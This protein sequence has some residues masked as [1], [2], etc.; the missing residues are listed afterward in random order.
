LA[1]R[2]AQWATGAVG[3]A[4]LQELIE[5]PDYQLVGVLVYDPAK[6]GQDA[7]ALCGLPPT[8]GVL[9]T[10]DK[11]EILAIKP[12]V[13]VHA[14]SKAHTVETN[15]EDIC[16]L[17]AAGISVITTT[18]YNHLPTYGADVEATFIEACQQGQSRFHAAGENPGF[19]FERLVAT[20]TALCKTIDRI[21]LYEA[22]DV[23]AVDSRPMLV[24]LMGMGR[25][26]EDVSIDSPIVKKLDMA[27]RQALN[28]TADVLGVTLSHVD[29]SVDAT[30]LSHDLE[31]LAGTI[32]AGTVVGQRFS[33]VG[34]WSGRTLLA[35]HEEWV[36]TRDLPQWGLKPLAPGEKAPL[37]RAVI[38]G[39]PS[40]DFQLDVGWD[41]ALPTGQHAQPGHLMIAMGAVRAIR[42]VLAHPPG[43]VTAP[44]FGAIQLG[45]GSESRADGA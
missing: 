33:W 1:I 39:T 40:F 27:Y 37:I 23:S 31:V 44:V 17:L 25:P 21:D 15:A 6:A 26:P 19:M 36:L 18:S 41:G 4:A 5:N 20:L 14:A 13:V 9:A 29:V 43:I 16:R 11:D 35:I 7:G 45:G 2:V 42:D 28:A 12:D 34:H 22:T 8:T 3:R 30:T 24:D 32:E 10:S 38:K